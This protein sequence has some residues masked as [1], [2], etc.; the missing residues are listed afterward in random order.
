[1]Y[2]DLTHCL[3]PRQLYKID[4]KNTAFKTVQMIAPNA[5]NNF[6]TCM[7][8]YRYFKLQLSSNIYLMAYTDRC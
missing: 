4:R 3:E 5:F 1:V 2:N 8:H 6:Q 7:N